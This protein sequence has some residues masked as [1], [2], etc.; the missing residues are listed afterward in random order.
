MSSNPLTFA[1]LALALLAIVFVVIGLVVRTAGGR[2]SEPADSSP[3]GSGR[4]VE[5]GAAIVAGLAI[6]TTTIAVLVTLLQA[7]LTVTIPVETVPIE[8]PAGVTFTNGPEAEIVGGGLDQATVLIDGLSVTT[9]LLLAGSIL[10]GGAMVVIIAVAVLRLAR[11]IRLGDPF[12]RSVATA[13]SV[14]AV[15]VLVGGILSSILGQLGAWNASREALYVWGW[16]STNPGV[17]EGLGPDG[18]PQPAG[19]VLTLEF[20]PILIGVSLAAVATAFQAGTRLRTRAE[21]AERDVAGLV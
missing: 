4:A 15:T 6:L 17:P 20:W 19:F 12:D 16:N 8:V 13:I 2:R 10:T 7:Q 11:G 5:I 21:E 1:L 9:R 14:T 3:T 18:W